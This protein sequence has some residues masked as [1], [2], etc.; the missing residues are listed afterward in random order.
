M[1][2]RLRDPLSL[3]K[4]LHSHPTGGEALLQAILDEISRQGGSRPP[5]DDLTLLTAT[6]L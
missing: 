2:A 3:G 6:I 4:S 1:R 5:Q